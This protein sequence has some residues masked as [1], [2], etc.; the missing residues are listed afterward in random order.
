MKQLHCN[1]GGIPL[2]DIDVYRRNVPVDAFQIR[3]DSKMTYEAMCQSSYAAY[4]YKALKSGE[5]IDEDRLMSLNSIL[6]Y[7]SRSICW[8]SISDMLKY[9]AKIVNDWKNDFGIDDKK[10][11]RES[12]RALIA[13]KDS[14]KQYTDLL[15]QPYVKP[16]FAAYIVYYSWIINMTEFCS[17]NFKVQKTLDLTTNETKIERSVVFD[18]M[19]KEHEIFI[20]DDLHK[21]SMFW[22]PNTRQV[23]EKTRILSMK[24]FNF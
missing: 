23:T 9:E 20:K 11:D 15:A 3:P 10:T 7:D 19:Q 13:K 14:F 21:F 6:Q 24:D 22:K 5:T 12:L 17:W 2:L 4:Y 16:V 18:I 8:R 1:I